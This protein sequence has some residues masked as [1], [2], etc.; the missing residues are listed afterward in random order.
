MKTK[1]CPN[2]KKDNATNALVCVYCG[3]TF[4]ITERTRTAQIPDG[5]IGKS[6][7]EH[8]EY[9]SGLYKD[10][11][12][13]FMAH[14]LNPIVVTNASKEMVI[15]RYAD[16]GTTISVD[17]EEFGGSQLG[18]SRR[19]AKIMRDADGCKL[20]D[21]ESKNG[22]WLNGIQLEK[23]V[24]H[25]IRSG[26]EIRLGQM[27]LHVY[28]NRAV[29]EGQSVILIKSR[30]GTTASLR[31]RLTYKDIALDLS[32]FLRAIGDGQI[33]IDQIFERTPY[34][35]GVDAVVANKQNGTVTVTLDGAADIIPLIRTYI[36]PW[37]QEHRAMIDEKSPELSQRQQ[38]L[39][40]ELIKHLKTG[41]EPEAEK[42][43]T[44]Q[45]LPIVQALIF[46]A[47]DLSMEQPVMQP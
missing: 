5:P 20:V 18:V 1:V 8:V 13:F 17:L 7:L 23:D 22:T 32:P 36:T 44:Q 15:G 37:K 3:S 42:E 41:L 12:I 2:C 43:Y 14:Q 11:F 25:I 24:P 45:F 46:S 33:L 40:L 29:E 26:D 35:M 34:E 10:V 39:V 28:F 16:S 38:E 31:S 4:A 9:L 19:H 27:L 6:R 47:F 30:Q 21:L